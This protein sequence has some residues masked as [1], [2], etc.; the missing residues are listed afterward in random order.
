VL[1]KE[2]ILSPEGYYKQA[3]FERFRDVELPPNLTDK[4]GPMFEKCVEAAATID[5]SPADEFCKS[6]DPVIKCFLSVIG[7]V[8]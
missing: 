1:A 5:P 2:G 6:Y 8:S 7:D 4:V 3:D